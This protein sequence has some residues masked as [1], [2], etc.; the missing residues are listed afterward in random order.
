[1]ASSPALEASLPLEDLAHH[2]TADRFDRCEDIVDVDAVARMRSRSMRI[3][4]VGNPATCSTLTSAAPSM[5]AS[6]RAT[7]SA[8]RL[9]VCKSLP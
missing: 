7:P 3:R 6:T 8:L 2:P 1:M 5:S 9:R 4:K